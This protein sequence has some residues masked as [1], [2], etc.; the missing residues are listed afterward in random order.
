MTPILVRAFGRTGTTLLM[1]LLNSSRGILVPNDY[2][3]ESRYLSYFAQVANLYEPNN[4]DGFRDRHL[5]DNTI[6]H[7]GTMP[8]EMDNLLEQRTFK[9][10]LFSYSWNQFCSLVK[11]EQ[12]IDYDYYAEKVQLSQ[13]SYINERI[14]N[15]K[16]IFI[17]RDPRGELAS[18]IAFNKKRGLNGFG[19]QEDD[20]ELTFAERMVDSRVNYFRQLKGFGSQN[21]NII[22]LRFEDLVHDLEGM[23]KKL[24]CFLNVKLDSAVVRDNVANMSHHMTSKSIERSSDKWKEELLPQTIKLFEDA[25]ADELEAFS[26]L[27]R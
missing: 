22:V 9:D 25:M 3:Y 16:N 5:M 14:D 8:Y 4:D 6:R 23:A 7:V 20:T 10:N 11:L 17:V 27:Q 18:I 12:C 15:V 2:P 24:S 1:Q 19:W 13:A 21:K 26:Y